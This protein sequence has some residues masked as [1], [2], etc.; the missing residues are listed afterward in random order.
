MDRLETTPPAMFKLS[1]TSEATIA[2]QPI[3]DLRE[4]VKDMGFYETLLRVPQSSDPAFHVH[5]LT[6][7]EQLGFVHHLDLFVLSE[8]TDLLRV[9]AVSHVA[10][11][12]SQRSVFDHGDTIIRRLCATKMCERITVEITETARIPASWLSAF[13]AGVRA[14]GCQLAVDDFETGFA[15]AELVHTVKP[16]ILKI[17][18]DDTSQFFVDRL[19]RTTTLAREIGA[20]VVME[21]IDGTEKSELAREY[22][23]R[24]GQGFMLAQPILARDLPGWAAA[25]SGSA[26]IAFNDPCTTHIRHDLA[27]GFKPLNGHADIRFKEKTGS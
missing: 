21:K 25:R 20:D 4:G 14:I 18:M 23:V 12:V 2:L 11:N 24:Y 6:L 1:S 15:D 13:T 26:A 8:V 19:A 17:A 9:N 3:F 5:L 22:G 16:T 7:A 10:V 27:R